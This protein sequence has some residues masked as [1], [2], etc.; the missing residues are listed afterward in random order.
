M[1][2]CKSVFSAIIL[3]LFIFISS[4]I[5]EL[6][7]G[8]S[9]SI[10]QSNASGIQL[11]DLG[12]MWT[13]DSPP[14][15]YWKET[16]NFEPTQEWLEK[17]RLSSP[18]FANWCSSG[19]VSQD[20]LLITNHHCIDFILENFQDEGEDI[21]KSGFCAKTFEEERRVKDLFVDQL[22]EIKDV[23]DEVLNA[24][25]KGK[26]DEEMIKLKNEKISEIIKE[27]SENSDLIY[28]VTKLYKGGRYSLYGV[29]RYNDVRAVLAVERI[30]GLY[31]GD[32][33]NYTYPRY[34]ADFAILRVYEDG[35]PLKTDNYFP[36]K[37]TGPGPNDILFG[38]GNPGTTNRLRTL[39]QLLFYR[40]YY[41]INNLFF[42]KGIKRIYE[43]LIVEHPEKKNKYIGDVFGTLNVIKRWSGHYK[44]LADE[45]LI[46][47][48][49]EFEQNFKKEVFKSASLREKYGHV[50]DAISVGRD[51]LAKVYNEVEA[52]DI[53][54]GASATYFAIAYRLVT[55]AEQKLLP[56]SERSDAY[57]KNN[58]DTTIDKI[59][60][61]KIDADFEDKFFAHQL[62]YISFLL[63]KDHPLYK[64]IFNG[65]TPNEVAKDWLNE[66][67]IYDRDFV[68]KLATGDPKEIIN[69][70]DPVIKYLT[71]NREH[72]KSVKKIKT[73][74][75]GTENLLNDQL[76]VAL[77]KVYGS[78]IPPDATFTL[79][80]TD[81]QLKSYEYNGTR[82]PMFTTF[83]GLYDR[84]YSH[85]KEFPWDIPESWKNPAPGFNYS[86]QYNLT[87]TCDIAGGNSG[88][89]LINAEGQYVGVLFDGNIESL[90]NSFIYNPEAGR[91]LAVSSQGIFEIVK[92][93]YQL[94]RIVRELETEKIAK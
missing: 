25:A 33:D 30:I 10:N 22:V 52:L 62:D 1:K 70:S 82:A 69:S 32:Y 91:S 47:R 90:A 84:Y 9:E 88:S 23:T 54:S 66:T 14:L 8:Q 45:K 17:V 6:L 55:L 4:S 18:K 76:G 59:Y 67:K 42:L 72:L 43:E 73:T 86:A 78:S 56:E 79:R 94:D 71:E 36:F 53:R 19:F 68:L 27:H 21:S 50:W 44:S 48:K 93:I 26:T 15:S 38:I 61:K 34:N 13:F 20:G 75:F 89:P 35:K 46:S 81:G 77:Y 5:S 49:K 85:Q 37:T 92:N 29:K 80:I 28:D 65:K 12:K 39:S 3:T 41:L 16:Y 87:T 2:K 57:N 60:P 64:K 11:I 83:Y 40:D 63:G 74:I 51:E 31:G 24:S 7:Y 58:I